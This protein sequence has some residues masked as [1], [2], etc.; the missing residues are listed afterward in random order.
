MVEIRGHI[1]KEVLKNMS[2]FQYNDKPKN[3]NTG[4]RHLCMCPDDQQQP[5]H[6][7]DAAGNTV[8]WCKRCGLYLGLRDMDAYCQSE[9]YLMEKAFRKQKA[10]GM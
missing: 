9:T 10:G 3:P 1:A 2:E 4:I 8:Y 5:A 7:S 6:D